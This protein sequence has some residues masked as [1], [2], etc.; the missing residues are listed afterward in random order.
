MKEPLRSK[1]LGVRGVPIIATAIGA[2]ALGAFAIGVLS[3]RKLA[4]RRVMVASGVF[5]SLEIQD[6]IVTRIHA[7][8]V[9]VSDSLHLP[10]DRKIEPAMADVGSR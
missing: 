2:V 9:T 4:I 1:S 6:L 8:E 3:I 5:K 10:G 7:A